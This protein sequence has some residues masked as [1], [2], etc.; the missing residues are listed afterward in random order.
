MPYSG[1]KS[2]GY[3]HSSAQISKWRLPGQSLLGCPPTQGM[4]GLGT[5][6]LV[7]FQHIV[8][9]FRDVWLDPEHPEVGAGADSL[10][11]VFRSVF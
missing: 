2:S 1:L 9:P 5:V 8:Y 11:G 10:L 3:L 4:V 7:H 6:F